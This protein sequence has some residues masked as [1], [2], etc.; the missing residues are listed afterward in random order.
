MKESSPR[1]L[2]RFAKRLLM[3]H[4]IASPP[5]PLEKLAKE[6]GADLRVASVNKSLRGFFVAQNEGDLKRNIIFV[7]SAHLRSAQRW[8][9]AHELGHMLLA[10]RELHVDW[11]DS[12]NSRDET[13]SR[14]PDRTE[15]LA[16]QLALELLLPK[17][18]LSADV[19]KPLD[20]HDDESLERLA[21]RYEVSLY[22]VI[23]RLEQLRLLQPGFRT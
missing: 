17:Q 5:V 15:S 1:E 22:A 3:K 21:S 19:R 12:P 14:E 16:D 9:L 7:N 6:M 10:T 20:P 18:M 4:G 11:P 23:S 2:E 8:T 13:N